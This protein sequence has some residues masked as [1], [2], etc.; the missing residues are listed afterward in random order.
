[1]AVECA[2]N[3]LAERLGIDPIDLRLKNAVVEGDVP[4]FGLPFMAIGLQQALQAAKNHPNYSV[5]LQAGQGRGVACAF[6]INAGM[7][8]SATINVAADGSLH[9]LT[10]NPDIGGL[11]LQQGGAR[12]SWDGQGSYGMIE[13]SYPADKMSQ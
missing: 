4:L 9:V 10:G 5:P 12:Y 1:M 8:S 6:W 11:N 13:R 7:Q 3:E 2:V